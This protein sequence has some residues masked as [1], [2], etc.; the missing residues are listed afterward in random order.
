V[1]CQPVLVAGKG[2]ARPP[3]PP[4]PRLLNIGPCWCRRTT[5]R[6]IIAMTALALISTAAMACPLG[7]TQKCGCWQGRCID[8]G[9]R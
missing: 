4:R 5:M 6:L 7:E 1:L 3:I 9:H 8:V 2:T